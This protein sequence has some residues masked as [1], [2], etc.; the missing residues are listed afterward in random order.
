MTRDHVSSEVGAPHR[1]A[2]RE[3]P[4]HGRA[5]QATVATVVLGTVFAACQ[6]TPSRRAS[7]ISQVTKLSQ[8]EQI[9][10]AI[11]SCAVL[12]EDPAYVPLGLRYR[13]DNDDYVKMRAWQILT[14]CNWPEKET[15]IIEGLRHPS[16]LVRVV[17]TRAAEECMEAS[18]N[19]D[20]ALEA[21]LV[22]DDDSSVVQHAATAYVR[23]L[24][25]PG[26]ERAWATL[27]AR[28]DSW[29]PLGLPAFSQC[30]LPQSAG[31]FTA[32][33]SGADPDLA[34]LANR[35]L[36]RIDSARTDDSVRTQATASWMTMSEFQRHWSDV[37]RRRTGMTISRWNDLIE[38]CTAA[39]VVV[40]GESH[41][42]L[43]E[44]AVQI[45]LLT[46]TI[47]RSGQ[48]RVAC[49][50]PVRGFQQPL[51]DA[52]EQAGCPV[53]FLEQGDPA[54][55]L[56]HER[57]E[58]AKAR[59]LQL[60]AED[61]E[62]R[63]FVF[64]GEAHRESFVSTLRERGIRIVA[65]SLSGWGSILADAWRARGTID[66]DDIVFRYPDKT[67]FVPPTTT[68][69]MLNCPQLDAALLRQ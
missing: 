20:R 4:A 63:W 50:L 68:G 51:I 41:A 25:D 39:R 19:L 65:V 3:H 53:V 43:F 47:T 23:R 12:L 8:D 46:E 2:A 18:E 54:T 34:C 69:L 67:Y 6:S 5:A 29:L 27:E 37:G 17:A 56:A 32:A 28:G 26:G 15:Y 57:D 48:V 11:L 1:A 31:L 10:T 61:P 33:A 24:G 59:L 30:T 22:E 38:D 60:M 13:D 49:E 52:A 36:A 9:R 66:I 21:V 58:E 14:L 40:V 7:L 62:C 45:R 64:Y 42:S 16:R 55:R 44:R 35:G